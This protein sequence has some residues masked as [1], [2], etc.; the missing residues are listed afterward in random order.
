[1][2]KYNTSIRRDKTERRGGD[3]MKK[4]SALMLSLLL[5]WPLASCGAHTEAGPVDGPDQGPPENSSETQGPPIPPDPGPRGT[6]ARF[7]YDTLQIEVSHVRDIVPRSMVGDGGVPHDYTLF[8]CFP[9]AEAVVLSAGTNGGNVANDGKVHARWGFI[10]SP[11]DE[12]LCIT[13]EMNSQSVSVAGARGVTHLESSLLM[14]AFEI[15]D[16]PVEPSGVPYDVNGDGSLQTWEFP[17]PTGEAFGLEGED[18]ALYTAAAKAKA[19][20]ILPRVRDTDTMLLLPTLSVWGAYDGENG[21]R[22]YICG[23]GEQFYYD[24]GSGLQDIKHPRYSSSG[25]G[26]NP[27]RITLAADGTLVDVQETY[28]GADNT[29]R[30]QELCG[31]L[32]E[33]ANAINKHEDIP[34][35]GSVPTGNELLKMYWEYYFVK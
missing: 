31:P 19:D 35:R 34:A 25:G 26:G 18:A 20:L 28:D 11:T 9:E 27:A 29:A 2:I 10:L 1:M 3:K 4:L 6:T 24:L 32:T 16:T 15:N 17:I 7:C 22:H 30:I 21:E 8:V 14:L 13:D 5:V 33:L 12:L 23:Y